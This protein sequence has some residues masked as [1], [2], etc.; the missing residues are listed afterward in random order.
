MANTGPSGGSDIES[1]RVTR[2]ESR[3]V[4][5]HQISLLNDLDDKAM[6]TTRTAVVLLGIII[7]AAG[8]IGADEL[9]RLPDL[10][11]WGY[12]A[13]AFGLFL[14][15]IAGIIAYSQSDMTFGVGSLHRDE[16]REQSYTEREWLGLLLEEYDEW[17]SEMR[18]VNSRNA[19]IVTVTQFLLGVS[20]FL[21]F[22]STVLL[23]LSA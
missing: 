2:E 17:T 16:V 1:L 4:L 23:A 19:S 10:V 14:T 11:F 7:S 12:G 6:R 18:Y 3:T 13:G 9:A 20:M 21:L 8:I 22:A 15:T 5:D